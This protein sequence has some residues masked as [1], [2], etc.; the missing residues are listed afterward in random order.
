MC[1]FI[2]VHVYS[3][4]IILQ[5][6]VLAVVTQLIILPS[7]IKIIK[8]CRSQ[9]QICKFMEKIYLFPTH[10]YFKFLNF[11]PRTLQ[12]HY[13]QGSQILAIIMKSIFFVAAIATLLTSVNAASDPQS[14]PECQ[15]GPCVS[16]LFNLNMFFF[17]FFLNFLG[18]IF[19]VIII[20]L[21]FCF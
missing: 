15:V 14:A 8:M 3:E 21:R 5:Y 6:R 2:Y 16:G 4:F 20:V 17:F 12:C 9:Q 1:L 13:F 18:I 19:A 11:R 10:F 7:W